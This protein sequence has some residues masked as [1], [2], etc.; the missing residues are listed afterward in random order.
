MRQH[1][2]A[3]QQDSTVRQHSE[4]A[5]SDST[6][7]QHSQ[8]ARVNKSGAKEAE[9]QEGKRCTEAAGKERANSCWWLLAHLE[10]WINSSRS[11]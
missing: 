11:K 6:A 7:R 1:S 4:T 3:A 5:W 8:T 10:H 2:E 9:R